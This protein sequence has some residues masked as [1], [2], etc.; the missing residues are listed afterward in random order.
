[1]VQG[2]SHMTFIV[3][4][5]DR[6]EEILTTVFDA[7]KVY[8]SGAETF[9]LSKERFFLIGNGKEPIWIA[10]ME[11]EPL[12]TRTYNHV[13]FKIANNEYEAYLKRIRA[14]GLE[15]REGRSRVPGEGQSIY[16]YDDDN[17]MFELHTGT[18]DERLKRYGQG[19]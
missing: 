12:P 4:D 6:M 18:L 3:R 19:R 11:G 2:L 1:M 13:A 8:D 10:T 15:V 14:L 5:L 16:F 7:R 17:H 9:S